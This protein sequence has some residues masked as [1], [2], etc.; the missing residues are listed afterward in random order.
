MADVSSFRS[1]FLGG[2]RQ[3]R[4]IVHGS[5]GTESTDLNDQTKFFV[6]AGQLP[7]S[8]VGIIPVPYRGRIVKVPGD[9]QYL[10]WPIVCY[11]QAKNA[12][13]EPGAEGGAVNANTIYRAMHDWSEQINDHARNVQSEDWTDIAAGGLTEW[14]IAH[15]DLEG[16]ALKGYKLINCWPVEVGSIDLSFDALDTV[17]EFPVTLAYDHFVPLTSQELSGMNLVP[18]EPAGN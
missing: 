6:K 3:N 16:N 15:L 12:G 18:P 13:S 2:T 7:P 5:V 1:Q 9:R 4:F 8:T 14:K 11:D 10:E 17:V